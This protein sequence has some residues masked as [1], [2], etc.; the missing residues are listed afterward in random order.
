M[1]KNTII[2]NCSDPQISGKTIKH[3]RAKTEGPIENNI[4]YIDGVLQ[5]N[6]YIS[7]TIN[8]VPKTYHQIYF[9]YCLWYSTGT[10]K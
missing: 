8:A 3:R 1:N 7:N 9:E 4:Q 6:V 10:H 5:L 2:G